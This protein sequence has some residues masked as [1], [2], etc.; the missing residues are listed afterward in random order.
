M[1]IFF[2]PCPYSEANVETKAQVRPGT[3]SQASAR[4]Q[5]SIAFYKSIGRTQLAPFS[6]HCHN[7]NESTELWGHF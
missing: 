7:S 1:E 6:P 3:A 4:G 2:F 5:I